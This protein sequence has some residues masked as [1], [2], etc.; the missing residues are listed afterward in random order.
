MEKEREINNGYPDL[1][2]VVQ[3]GKAGILITSIS[4]HT[5][6]PPNFIMGVCAAISQEERRN[7]VYWSGNGEITLSTEHPYI[8][9]LTENGLQKFFEV[10]KDFLEWEFDPEILNPD[11]YFDTDTVKCFFID[12]LR[13]FH[14]QMDTL[15]SENS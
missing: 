8:Y 6:I 9:A 10:Y 12:A 14:A 1:Q 13:S 7:D 4:E 11:F 3:D 5:K 15:G 2:M